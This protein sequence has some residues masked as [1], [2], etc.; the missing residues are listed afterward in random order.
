MSR[1]S[2]SLS[3]R[4]TPCPTVSMPRRPARPMSWVSSPLVSDA[5]L[6]PSNFVKRRDD[7]RARRHVEP[8][9]ER[10]GGEHHL[11]Q[12]LL[13]EPLHGLLRVGEQ[14]G[15]MHREPAPEQTPVELEQ[16]ALALVRVAQRRHALGERDVDALLLLVVGEVDAVH[17]ASLQRLAAAPARE[18]EVDGG[19]HRAAAQHLD[20]LEQIVVGRMPCL[21]KARLLHRIRLRELERAARRVAG[22]VEQRVQ[23]VVD[24]EPH[25]ERD[26]TLG[27]RHRLDGAAQTG[28]PRRDLTDVAD[29]RRESDQADVLRRLDD[30]LLP[31]GAARVVVDVVDLV[32]HDVADSIDARGLVVEDVAQNLGGHH[33]HRR[34]VVERVL[35]GDQARCAA[36]RS[37]RR[38]RDTSGC[39]ALSAAS[40]T[41]RPPRR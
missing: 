14:T 18:D 36:R 26:R 39:S 37:A 40:C 33:Q 34:A 5:K 7:A 22:L 20:H 30:Q 31:H 4:I 21:A 12:P 13:K 3:L 35:A 17:A 11:D 41:R 38:G 27:P 16:H 10:L 23:R 25:L 6:T 19:E 9:R 2:T 1:R 32:E 8:E 24:G 28:H 29:R 15:V